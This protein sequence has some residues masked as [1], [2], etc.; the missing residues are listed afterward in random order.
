LLYINDITLIFT[1]SLH[2]ALPILL[3]LSAVILG[4]CCIASWLLLP[5]LDVLA[6]GREHAIALGVNHRL[7]VSVTLLLVILMVALST[8][9]VGPVSF[10]GLIVANLAYLLIDRKSTRLNSS[11][12]KISYAV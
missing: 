3:M 12:V 8:A 9:L 6:L 2:D 5:K 1:L 10:F 7:M 4:A 11:H